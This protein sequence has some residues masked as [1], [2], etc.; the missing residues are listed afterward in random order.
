M[1]VV[2]DY[3]D[4]IKDQFEGRK[5]LLSRDVMNEFF[6]HERFELGRDVPETGTNDE[7]ISEEEVEKYYMNGERKDWVR[8]NYIFLRD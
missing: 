6:K 4:K 1:N 7:K 5:P 8:D 2:I 3:N